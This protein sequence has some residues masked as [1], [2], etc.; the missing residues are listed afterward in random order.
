MLLPSLVFDFGFGIEQHG[1]ALHEKISPDELHTL[2]RVLF[3]VEEPLV[4]GVFFS[5]IVLGSCTVKIKHTFAF[6]TE[7]DAFIGL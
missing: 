1:M 5:R 7:T 3:W 4:S 6:Y 2:H